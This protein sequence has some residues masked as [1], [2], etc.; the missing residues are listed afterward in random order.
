MG[1]ITLKTV[2]I[3]LAVTAE[4]EQVIADEI[5]RMNA[6]LVKNGMTP[7]WNEERLF[8]GWVH[9]A[10]AE[11]AARERET[12][13]YEANLAALTERT[14]EPVEAPAP[15]AYPDWLTQTFNLSP[16][17]DLVERG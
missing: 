11:I 6:W 2:T 4:Q 5:E 17:G 1:P 14:Q 10:F 15:P 12:A 8:A 9:R 13:Q 16:D 7:N 3:E